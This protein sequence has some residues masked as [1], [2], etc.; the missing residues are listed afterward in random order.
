MRVRPRCFPKLFESGL[1]L[2]GELAGAHVRES[3][4]TARV[5]DGGV[6][7]TGVLSRQGNLI[8]IGNTQ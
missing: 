5:V 8:T 1:E 4:V 7:A 3:G 6:T 2:A